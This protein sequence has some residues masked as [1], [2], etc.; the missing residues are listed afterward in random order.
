MTDEIQ[1]LDE[2]TGSGVATETLRRTGDDESAEPDLHP[3]GQDW[4]GAPYKADYPTSLDAR[5]FSAMFSDRR[6][7]AM[8]DC[9][10]S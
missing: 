6:N 1:P 8:F 9:Q 2:G 7:K 3:F 4:T 5:R 10:D